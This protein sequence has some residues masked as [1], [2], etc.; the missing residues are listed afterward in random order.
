MYV[1]GF[2]ESLTGTT[3]ALAVVLGYAMTMAS[4]RTPKQSAD[5][6]RMLNHIKALDQ[7]R[8]RLQQ[9]LM[10]AMEPSEDPIDGLVAVLDHPEKWGKCLE[11]T[12]KEIIHMVSFLRKITAAESDPAKRSKYRR[13][14]AEI[15]EQ[16]KTQLTAENVAAVSAQMLG[17]RKSIED[18]ID[19]C[20]SMQLDAMELDD[21]PVERKFGTWAELADYVRADMR[22]AGTLDVQVNE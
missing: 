14:L 22:R 12:R 10:A 6:K 13:S 15:D 4:T 19:L 18:G 2:N 7:K 1:H 21:A 8:L 5:A 9:E 17:M 20:I 16:L 11:D 3:T